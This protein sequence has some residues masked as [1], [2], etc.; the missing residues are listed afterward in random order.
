MR[1]RVEHVFGDQ[2]NAMEAVI[3]DAAPSHVEAKIAAA[4]VDDFRVANS[5]LTSTLNGVSKRTSDLQEVRRFSR[6]AI[7]P[8]VPARETR[9]PAREI[10]HHEMVPRRFSYPRAQLNLA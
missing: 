4:F 1:A 9:V 2:K 5:R 6:R 3:D 7:K 8:R 10:S